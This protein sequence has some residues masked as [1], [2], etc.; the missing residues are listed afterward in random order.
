MYQENIP[1][2]QSKHS[3]QHKN[4]GE[5][6]SHSS[7]SSYSS[8]SFS[9]ESSQE[10]S[11]ELEIEPCQDVFKLYSDNVVKE[12]YKPNKL[13]SDTVRFLQVDKLMVV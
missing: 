6:I 5:N 11:I 2:N 1:L 8:S 4:G 12:K 9:S 3:N 13:Q 7:R 10:D